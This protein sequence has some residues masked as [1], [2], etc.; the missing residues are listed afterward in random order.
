MTRG[1]WFFRSFSGSWRFDPVGPG[2]TRVTFS[3][4]LSGRPG[5]LS[6]IL[7]FILARE[8]GRRLEALKR[9]AEK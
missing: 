4:S 6:G 1:P 5:F 3:Y 2:R 9:A 7:R 8:T